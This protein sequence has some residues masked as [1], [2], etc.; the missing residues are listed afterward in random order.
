MS[1]LQRLKTWPKTIWASPF[2]VSKGKSKVQEKEVRNTLFESTLLGGK[3]T[4]YFAAPPIWTPETGRSEASGKPRASG[5]VARHAAKG[6]AA[7]GG[8]DW[9]RWGLRRVGER[10][11]GAFGAGVQEML[12]RRVWLTAASNDT[13]HGQVGVG[14]SDS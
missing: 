13:P 3:T 14:H 11:A 1:L 5:A 6:A 12:S 9:G 8:L 4:P 2:W 10:K 7:E